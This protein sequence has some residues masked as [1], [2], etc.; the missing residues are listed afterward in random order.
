M[1]PPKGHYKTIIGEKFP[2][3]RIAFTHTPIIGCRRVDYKPILE[4]LDNS[5]DVHSK[6]YS[7][8]IRNGTLATIEEI[9]AEKVFKS[10]E[11]YFK[12]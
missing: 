12:S 10:G 5:T 3:V 6:F 11:L 7:D 4:V 9:Q 1:N 8:G 2:N